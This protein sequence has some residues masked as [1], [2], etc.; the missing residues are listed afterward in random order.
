MDC[1]GCESYRRM[2]RRKWLQTALGTA[3]GASFLG[4]LDPALL[5]AVGKNKNRTADSVILLWMRGGMSHLDTFDLQPGTDH[6]GPFESIQTD[7][8]DIEISQHL[9]QLARQF[10]HLSVIRSMTS[11]EF[12]HSRAT[13][14]MHTGY[15]PIA[16]MQHS[17]IGSIVSKYK[18]RSARDENLP[19]YVSIGQDWA[20][21]YLG[22]KYAPYYIGD[23][24]FGDE[25][26]RM[27][28]GLGERR[29]RSRLK[30][31]R[32]FDK[33][34]RNKHPRNDALEAYAEHYDA[35]LL[36]MRPK[37]AKVFDLDEEPMEVRE[38]YGADSIFGQGCL[39]ARR[40]V[41]RGVRFVEVSFGGWDTHAN[42]FETVQ[43]KSEE[44]DTA[45]SML[46]QDLR[47][48]NLFERTVVLLTSEFG[49]TP[50][51]N[52]NQGRDH[53]PGVWS[54][55]IGGGG[56]QP[57]Q[58]IGETDQGRAVSDR[59][60]RVGDLHATLCKALGI[61]HTQSNYSSD[62]RPFRI[63]KEVDARPIKELFR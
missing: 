45:F 30:L 9:P 14:Q 61:D 8:D 7:A 47:R 58:V 53:F 35:A 62:K 37:T 3:G 29:F 55:V 31:L 24:R 48:K 63:V 49:R 19:P 12:D 59:P 2:T 52:E 1:A 10:K 56:I 27:P 34:F 5:Y 60:V 33:T 39:L 22:P 4:L 51:I 20:A 44:L 40:L 13:Y 25:N 46:V 6:G 16:S 54:S 42:N 38:A 26:L 11:N 36:M 15:V 50:R 41:Q 57:G 23:A 28:L 18:G 17:T 21:G 32:E 43:Q